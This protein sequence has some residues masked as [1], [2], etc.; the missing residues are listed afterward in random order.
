MKFPLA[1]FA[2]VLDAT[3]IEKGK[4]WYSEGMVQHVQNAKECI[5]N[6]DIIGPNKQFK[7]QVEIVGK[8]VNYVFCGCGPKLC[9]HVVALLFELVEKNYP[10]EK[11]YPGT[12]GVTTKEGKFKVI[13]SPFSKALQNIDLSDLKDFVKAYAA[14]NEQFRELFLSRFSKIDIDSQVAR[15]KSI[16]KST[17]KYDYIRDAMDGTRRVLKDAEKNFKEE[18]YEIVFAACKAVLTE[19]A[20]YVYHEKHAGYV[21]ADALKQL[22]DVVLCDDL[23]EQFKATLFNYIF[24]LYKGTDI[25]DYQSGEFWTDAFILTAPSN[26]YLQKVAKLIDAKLEKPSQ[27]HKSSFLKHK[28][29]IEEAI[30]KN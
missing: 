25:E 1:S 9:S 2:T 27:Y 4:R 26:E 16:I 24:L 17:L 18:N 11:Y 7:V 8:E 21:F 15:F 6:A 30:N 22:H 10:T 5:W 13:N 3:L 12:E 20:P 28:H 19:W 14:N 29:S 23:S